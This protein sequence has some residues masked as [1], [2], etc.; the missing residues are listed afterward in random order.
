MR[1]SG[2]LYEGDSFLRPGPAYSDGAASVLETRPEAAELV[3]RSI[4]PESAQ[5]DS[6]NVQEIEARARA[7]RAETVAGW[8]AAL[9]TRLTYWL[10]SGRR[11]QDEAYLARAENHADLEARIRELDRQGR[12]PQV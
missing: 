1:F 5:I 4:G 12:A 9:A 11:R 10:E 6:R 2:P 7:L 8:L 3:Q